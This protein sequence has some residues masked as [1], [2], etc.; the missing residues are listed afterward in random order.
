MVIMAI[1]MMAEYRHHEW[2][3]L[4]SREFLTRTK[5]ESFQNIARWNDQISKH[6]DKDS[7]LTA[8][9]LEMGEFSGE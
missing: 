9:G 7:G 2:M 5:Q 6:A 3:P 4:C 1:C 8:T